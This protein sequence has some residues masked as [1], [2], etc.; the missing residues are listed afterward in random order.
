MRT[1]KSDKPE[2]PVKQ[3]AGTVGNLSAEQ[4]PEFTEEQQ[5]IIPPFEVI[6]PEEQT[7]AFEIVPGMTVEAMTATF[8]NVDALIEPPYEIWQLSR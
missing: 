2:S 3:V 1:K 4:F 5:Q 8:F 6:E 7:G